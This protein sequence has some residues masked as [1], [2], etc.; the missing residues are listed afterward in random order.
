MEINVQTIIN[1]VDSAEIKKKISDASYAAL[2]EAVQGVKADAKAL[3]PVGETGNLKK[4]IS[5][6]VKRRKSG[7]VTAHVFTKTFYGGFVEFGTVKNPAQPFLRPA[8]EK[9]KDAILNAFTG[10]L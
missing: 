1:L 6:T 3:C 7:T 8:V 4:S 10:K 5:T 2:K 9:N